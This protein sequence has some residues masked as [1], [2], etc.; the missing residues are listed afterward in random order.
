MKI[1]A[2][3]VMSWLVCL[4]SCDVDTKAI[5]ACGDGFV[6]PGE[7]CDLTVGDHTCQSLGHYRVLGVL[8]CSESCQFDRSDCGGICGDNLVDSDYGELC[9]GTH[10]NGNNCRLEGFHGGTLRCNHDCSGYDTSD[11]ENSGRCGDGVRQEEYE[12]CEGAD[13][14]GATCQSLGYYLG[15]L[16]CASSCTFD[17]SGCA[18]RCGDGIVQAAAGEQCDGTNIPGRCQDHGFYGGSLACG[19][20]CRLVT[21]SCVGSCGDGIIQADEG[22]DCEGS[23]L[24]GKTCQEFGFY[25]GALACTNQCT[26]TQAGCFFFC[27]D[28]I[29]QETFGETCDEDNLGAARCTDDEKL[30]GVPFCDSSCQTQFSSCSDTHVW[31]SNAMGYAVAV[32]AAGNMIVTGVTF[33]SMDGKIYNGNGDIFVKKFAPDGSPL[34]TVLFGNDSYDIGHSVAVDSMGNIVVAGRYGNY[35]GG[36]TAILVKLSPQGTWLGHH[37]WM[38]LGAQAHGVAVDG[39]DNIYV[40]GGTGIPLDEQTWTG[41]NDAFL[42]K[43]DPDLNRLWTRQWGSPGDEWGSKVAVDHLGYVYVSGTTWGSL[44]GAALRGS[45]DAF[46]T[47]FDTNG[48]LLWTRQWGTPETNVYGTAVACGSDGFVYV[49]GKTDTSATL[50]KYSAGGV[51][52][53]TRLWSNDGCSSAM[54]VDTDGFGGV[55]VSGVTDSEDVFLAKYNAS[56]QQQWTRTWGSA[57]YDASYGLAVD[58]A[59]NCMITGPWDLDVHTWDS[60]VFLT[61][62]FAIP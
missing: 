57:Q 10:L 7:E 35:D 26:F 51:H 42:A 5:A 8:R 40:T 38:Y 48:D 55:Y 17:T 27:G 14:G 37:L 20:D 33:Q 15:T 6:D 29:I 44:D 2:F 23:N 52:Q 9:D 12:A 13:L 54:A 19:A 36:Y 59:G 61:Y 46:L 25:G 45:N 3:L 4:G 39:D 24:D 50:V 18:E 60:V 43:F 16:A 58:P 41:E 56:G 49:A 34:W 1:R 31:G 22:E 21:D 28:G 47:R 53:W 30:F 11:C 32:D 62:I